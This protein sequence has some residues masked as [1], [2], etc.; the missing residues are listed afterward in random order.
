MSKYEDLLK[1][2]NYVAKKFIDYE[3]ECRNIIRHFIKI[4]VEYFN[5]PLESIEYDYL[6][7]SHEKK[8]KDL[9]SCLKFENGF[10][11]IKIILNLIEEKQIIP[12]AKLGIPLYF[13]KDKNVYIFKFK[14]DDKDFKFE[15]NEIDSGKFLLLFDYI[16][17]NYD[18]K[19]N[20]W[21][22]TNFFGYSNENKK[23]GF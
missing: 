11:S 18:D 13:R 7:D 22:D 16:Y 2:R 23:M 4:L 15:E 9:F 12:V 21:I 6:I 10:W 20:L 3:N 5:C 1:K 14:N 17:K 19:F 8:E